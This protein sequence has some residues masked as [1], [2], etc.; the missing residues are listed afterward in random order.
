[1]SR[2]Q[3]LKTHLRAIAAAS[4]VVA[5]AADNAL[6][7]ALEIEPDPVPEPPP[8]PPP[9]PPP[10]APS[11]EPAPAPPPAAAPSRAD[12]LTLFQTIPAAEV[13][14]RVPLGRPY[15]LEG[16]Y[17]PTAEHV[18]RYVGW[19]WDKTGG[20][21]IDADGV[22][23]GPK[24]WIAEPLNPAV[25]S[26]TVPYAADATALVKRVIADKRP[27]ALRL[28]VAGDYRVMAAF[29]SDTPPRVAVAYESGEVE[30][31]ACRL[32]AS[33]S[34]S[35]MPRTMDETMAL[36][37]FVEFDRPSRSDVKSATLYMVIV[38]H[39]AGKST[40]RAWLLDPPKNTDQVQHGIAAEWG[41]LDDGAAS[42]PRAIG[43]HRYLPNT[44]LADYALPGSFVNVG[45]ERE[46][47]P[48]IWGGVPDLS[49]LPH[50][51]D[52]PG[53]G[54][55]VNPGKGWS[56]VGPDYD[57]E[58]FRPLAPG[59]GALRVHMPAK[60][61]ADGDVVY[62]VGQAAADGFI[63]LP[64]PMFGRLGRIFVRQ[65]VFLG[66]RNGQPYHPKLAERLHVYHDTDR[67]DPVWTDAAGKF[68][69]TPEHRTSYG[70]VSGTAGGPNG[71]Q[72]RGSWSDC[73]A[74]MGGPDEGGWS[75]GYH[76][77]DFFSDNPPGHNYPGDSGRKSKFGQRGGLGG[78]L[79]ALQWVC[80]ETELK[81]N[82]VD[83]PGML[84][85]GSP[86]LVAG[87]P[88]FWTPDG[89]LRAWWNGRLAF[90]RTGMVFRTLPLHPLPADP[91]KIRPCR[92]LGVRGLW[93]NWFHGGKTLNAVDRTVFVTGLAWAHQYIGPMKGVPA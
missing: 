48:A 43:V 54:R 44:S 16:I 18:D 70:G 74:G 34:T 28:D 13:P 76:L 77:Y 89:E 64:E 15:R 40:L 84:A 82:S 92:E 5:R 29:N 91:S 87:Q 75:L 80:I 49:K 63:F 53:G 26:T 39:G 23:H 2:M 59:L 22:R 57:G 73:D 37:V 11:P 93:F 69:V 4:L 17:G 36:P 35:V 10:P 72:M 7:I 32:T 81:L 78:I 25:A 60:A 65:Y 90:E 55:W 62:S 56:I 86:H 20:D 38:K 85:D 67:L 33:I 31:L 24:P 83:K 12:S 42:D 6:T 1:M 61:L 51:A 58:G 8:A 27:F 3:E 66:T 21:W 46:F 79:P 88:Q 47:D 71:W 19:A 14:P 68:L 50:R 30:T 45:A 9:P 41:P 52:R